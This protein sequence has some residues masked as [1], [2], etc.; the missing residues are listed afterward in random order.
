MSC[1]ETRG[2][3][4]AYFDGE[5]DLI[6]SLDFER[7]LG[8]CSRCRG[9]HDQYEQLRQSLRASSLYFQA[10]VALEQ[11]I[12]AQLHRADEQKTKI[13][14]PKFPL[15]AW[16]LALVAAGLVLLAVFSAVLIEMFRRP[17]PS[18]VLAQQVVSSHIRS[19]M[20]NHLTDVSSTDQHTVKPWFN[21]KLDFA[22]VVKDLA[23]QGFPLTGGRLDY[24]DGRSVAALVYKRHQHTINLFIWPS[25]QADSEPKTAAI[26]GYNLI[27]WTQSHMAYWAISD[28]NVRELTDFVRDE[29]K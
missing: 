20:A 23:H 28:L 24:L 4:D 12:R 1:Q 9:M 13:L 5:L 16:R 19:L 21:G 14:R 7:H 25:S 27:H 26:R 17:S 15:P 2:L 11:R 8:E 18:D 6:R 10:P 29:R 3:L 22:P